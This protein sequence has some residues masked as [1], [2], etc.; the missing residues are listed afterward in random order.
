MSNTKKEHK[1]QVI[2]NGLRYVGIEVL[3]V[4]TFTRD[5]SPAGRAKWQDDQFVDCTAVLP[6]EV[7]SKMERLIKD[8][9]A[10]DYYD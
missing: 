4:V 7:I 6:D 1:V 8:A 10:A 2:S 3:G 5:G 9:I